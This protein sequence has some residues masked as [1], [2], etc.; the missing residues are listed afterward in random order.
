MLLCCQALG[1]FLQLGCCL[2]QLRCYLPGPLC[3]LGVGLNLAHLGLL[4]CCMTLENMQL[5][6]DSSCN[7]LH[8]EIF[9][10]VCGLA[11]AVMNPIL[12]DAV[13][14]LAVTPLVVVSASAAV[15]V[16]LA[17]TAHWVVPV[18]VQD[19]LVARTVHD[20]WTGPTIVLGVHSVDQE[21]T[22]CFFHLL[23]GAG[24]HVATDC[25]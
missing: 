22:F 10:A 9:A 1:L 3:S 2:R 18:A 8:A 4:L 16:T 19:M 15:V 17:V 7:L 20:A 11:V 12:T 14:E 24:L 23:A 25:V 21:R 13:Y 5:R 6:R